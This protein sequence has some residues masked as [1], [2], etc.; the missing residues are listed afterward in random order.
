MFAINQY[1]RRAQTSSIF[2]VLNHSKFSLQSFIRTTLRK[3]CPN[4][5]YLS[6]LPIYQSL[7]SYIRTESCLQSI[8]TQNAL[9][10]LVYFEFSITLQTRYNLLSGQCCTKPLRNLALISVTSLIIFI[11][12]NHYYKLVT[13]SHIRLSSNP[14]VLYNS[15]I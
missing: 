8:S 2:R 1:S 12:N 14:H 13:K 3:T 6:H 10:S 11:I 5:S 15:T 9:K 4:F 7:R